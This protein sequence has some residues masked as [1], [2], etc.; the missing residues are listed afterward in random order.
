[1]PPP[2]RPWMSESCAVGS[3]TAK[4]TLWKWPSWHCALQAQSWRRWNPAARTLTSTQSCITT[5]AR[6][7]SNVQNTGTRYKDVRPIQTLTTLSI[8]MARE[9]GYTWQTVDSAVHW[10]K[11][12]VATSQATLST[13]Q[14]AAGF[15]RVH[16]KTSL[17]HLKKAASPWND[18]TPHTTFNRLF[19]PKHVLVAWNIWSFC[20]IKLNK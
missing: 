20:F 7:A 8:C 14:T 2:Q 5:T 13:Q 6:A 18:N 17:S 16:W 10:L 11:L 12:K 19:L 9:D 3:A 1:M 4:V 15:C